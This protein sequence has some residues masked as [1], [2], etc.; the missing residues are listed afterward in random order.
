M[1]NS[2]IQN[3]IQEKFLGNIK[4]LEEPKDDKEKVQFECK[5]HGI[6]LSRYPYILGTK[7]GCPK[8]GRELGIIKSHQVI[9]AKYGETGPLSNK[10][11]REKAKQT[12][13]ERYG[14]E[15]Y[16]N[17]K[18]ISETQKNFSEDKKKSIK[19]KREETNLENFGVIN[20]LQKPESRKNNKKALQ[21]ESV[22]KKR[23][24]T[25]E[26]KY[27]VKNVFC[28]DS[29]IREKFLKEYK[30]KT[31]YDCPLSNPECHEKAIQTNLNK[32][33]ET[34]WCK[35]QEAREFFSEMSKDEA[36]IQKRLETMKERKTFTNPKSEQYFC[37][38]LEELGLEYERNYKTE[39]YPFASDFYIPKF[40]MFV[41]LNFHWTHGGH[42][43]DENNSDDIEKV[44]LWKSKNKEYYD[45]AIYNWTVRDLKKK[46]YIEKNNINCIVLWNY[47]DIER[48]K[49]YII[50]NG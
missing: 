40:K 9:K 7:S 10:S 26:E 13:K 3:T 37:N 38:I 30:Q 45:N 31:G 18:Q 19:Q 16:N 44:M 11:C 6:F 32:Y 46:E 14:D 28:G 42:W 27:G 35:T 2:K 47:E 50:A 29:K 36:V 17:P 22:K 49:T 48:W 39:E 43:F 12:K 20:A 4:I 25:N 24:K 8:C 34:S 23:N 41:E 1:K 21:S 15:N 33:G 5:K